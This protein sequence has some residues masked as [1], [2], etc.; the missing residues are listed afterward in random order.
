MT[1][2]KTVSMFLRAAKTEAEEAGE[3]TEGMAN[4]VSELRAEILSLTGN[5][6]DIQIDENTFKSTYQIM[7]E[8]SEVW[9]SLTDLSQA[10]ITEMVGGK[11]NANVVSSLLENFSVAENALQTSAN[12]AG[13]ALIENEKQLASIQG[14]IN[15]M[16][17]EFQILAQNIIGSDVVKFFVSFATAVLKLF[18]GIIKVV[19]ALGGFKT[20]ILTVSSLLIGAKGSSIAFN[21][22][23]N[24]M[25]KLLGGVKSGLS[26]LINIIPTAVAA[27]SS[28]AKGTMTAKAAM[29][30]TIPVIGL[31]L[32]AI[33]VVSALKSK[34]ADSVETVP[35]AL[36]DVTQKTK[37]LANESLAQSQ[38]IANLSLNY[39]SASHALD[40]MSGSVDT[41]VNAREELIKGLG[42][43]QVELSKLIE[44]YGDYDK[45]L[46]QISLSKLKDQEINIRGGLKAANQEFH[47]LLAPSVDNSYEETN[48]QELL[49]AHESLKAISSLKMEFNDELFHITPEVSDA[50]VKE[51]GVVAAEYIAAYNTYKEALKALSDTVGADNIVYKSIFERYIDI[52][53]TTEEYITWINNLNENLAAQ[54]IIEKMASGKLPETKKEFEQ[55]RQD[56]IDTAIASDKFSGELEN[57]EPAI[58]KVL[59]SRSEFAN[60]YKIGAVTGQLSDLSETTQKL[61]SNYELLETAQKEMAEGEG[62]SASTIKALSDETN[63]Y[64]DYL[65][66]ENGI[67]KL[68][69]DAWKEYSDAKITESINV[70]K[71]KIKTL[72]AERSALESAK[73]YEDNYVG[74]IE[75]GAYRQAEHTARLKENTEEILKNQAQLG[76]YVS[77]YESIA[78]SLDAY[79]AALNNFS[80]IA[81]VITSVSDSLTIVAN[82]QK[83]VANGFTISLDKAL[84]FAKVYPEILNSATVAADGQIALNEGVIKSFIT[85]KESELKAQIDAEVA[86][87]EADKEVLNAKIDFAQAQLDIAQSVGEGE[88]KIS[89][90]LAQYKVRTGNIVAQSLIKA[91]V[92]EATAYKLACEA[93][94]QNTNEFNGI[95]AKV[96]KLLSINFDTAS[97]NI[98]QSMYNNLKNAATSLDGIVNAAHN[99]AAAVA[100]ISSGKIS[101][102]AGAF[103]GA[104]GTLGKLININTT[105]GSFKGTNFSYEAREISLGDFISELELDI[106]TY[107][108]AV[109]QIDGQI[110]ALKALRNTKLSDFATNDKKTGSSGSGSGSGSGNKDKNWF[111]KEYALHQH[112]LKMDAENVEDYL[113]WL[114]SA[115]QRAYKE[116]IIDVDGYYK[117]C[118]EVYKGLQDLFKDYLNDVEHEISMRENYEG[119]SDIIIALYEKLIKNVEKE[120]EA[121]RAKGLDDT[122]DYVQDLQSKWQS[123]SDSI[124]DIREKALESAK[125]AISKLIDYRIDMIKQDR[126]KEKEAL[127]KKLDNLKEFYDKQKEMLRDQYDEEQYLKEQSEKRKSVFDLQS[128]IAMLAN[129]DSAWAKKRKLELQDELAKAE[130]DLN[131]F[132]DKHALDEA[133]DVLDKAYNSQETQIKAEMNALEETLNDPEAL[134]NQ[135]LADIKNN[136]GQLYQEMLEYNRRHGSGNDE[137]IK[138]MYEKA[139]TALLEYKDIYGKDYEGIILSNSTNYVPNTGSWD[140]EVISGATYGKQIN[141]SSSSTGTPN[142]ESASSNAALSVGSTI[143][144]KSSA[145][146]YGSLSNG[147]KMASFVPGG[148]YTIYKT[149]GDQVLIGRDGVY[150]GWVN[151]SDIVGYAS[152]TRNATAGLHSLDELGSEYLFTSSDGASYRVLNSG[153]KVLNAKATDFIY[154]FANSGGEILD[155]IIKS[156]VGT[157]PIDRI[158]RTSNQNQIA[159]GDI[160]IQGSASHQTV[161]EIRRAQRD[162]LNELLKG[163]NNLNK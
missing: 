67:I 90:E 68:N 114:N 24:K 75:S 136:T 95:A 99:A 10:N 127:D 60:F 158:K 122:D 135:A 151:K 43:E 23:Q 148:S 15:A 100:G 129:D 11:R 78:G 80:N 121:A 108:S 53:K 161:S 64:L 6:V 46:S 102:I 52:Q 28:F 14:R 20:V 137:D 145:T 45:A 125:D 120:I 1:T 50:S 13:S 36:E 39:L 123:Y 110:A 113:N 153:D 141:T 154:K 133:L 33:S 147:V 21:S 162:N 163:L 156:F 115:Y 18:N 124:K 26:G 12:S 19:N 73:V 101:G 138:S 37:E 65:Y 89:I 107:Q 142:G 92:E 51:H 160:I 126:D 155:K 35:D 57:I 3:S 38:E 16:K 143:K 150:T 34:V 140:T 7:K 87:L 8:L 32:A 86:K 69:T 17:T 30:A 66:E 59:G 96:C 159:M 105:S 130:D 152:G 77:M 49:D 5:K 71:D 104:I 149:N 139:Y 82:L 118:E 29:R 88:G 144:V 94:A 79:S 132:E 70:F 131:Q 76:L 74:A 40:T 97:Y 85:G 44:K 93:M 81:N 25:I 128:E 72:E 47:G 48:K 42:I 119:E 98:A 111:E 41:Y 84:E 106:S 112:L 9:G 56:L 63:K 157:S 116:G 58:D 62:L 55:F 4:S 83:E 27:W 109:S 54:H 134:Y 2:L 103:S 61:K 31:V 22:Q 117:Y 91:G 146:H